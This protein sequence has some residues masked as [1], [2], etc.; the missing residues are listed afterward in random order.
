MRPRHQRLAVAAPVP[1][2]PLRLD[3]PGFIVPRIGDALRLLSVRHAACDAG[4][5]PALATL[6]RR[7]RAEAFRRRFTCLA[8]GLHEHDPLRS[9][10]RGIPRFTFTSLAFATSLGSAGRLKELAQGI[11]FED[12]ALVEPVEQQMEKCT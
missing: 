11:P 4:H 2:A 10:V 1:T 5:Q 9:L 7:A 12:Y 3:M 8:L 6:L